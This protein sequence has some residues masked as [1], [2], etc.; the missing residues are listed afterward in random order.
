M[1]KAG[2]ATWSPPKGGVLIIAVISSKL[3]KL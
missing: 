1:Q 2:V 3:A